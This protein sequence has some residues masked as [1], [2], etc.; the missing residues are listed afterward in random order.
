M[1]TGAFS[2]HFHQYSWCLRRTELVAMGATC[3]DF[4]HRTPPSNLAQTACE[5]ARTM[6]FS[7]TPFLAY[8]A[9]LSYRVLEGHPDPCHSVR[10]GASVQTSDIISVPPFNF[11]L[12]LI[13][14]LK[15]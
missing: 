1:I 11:Q 9:P 2:L 7:C 5:A 4:C 8:F 10:A 3:P 13:R 12:V 6:V 15:R 14:D